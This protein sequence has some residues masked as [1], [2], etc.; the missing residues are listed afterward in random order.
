MGSSGEGMFFGFA[1][2]V[3]LVLFCGCGCE[4][5]EKSNLLGAWPRL[6]QDDAF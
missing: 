1:L 6:G 5:G 2:G 4:V 3:G